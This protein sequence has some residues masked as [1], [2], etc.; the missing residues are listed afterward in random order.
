MAKILLK[1]LHSII[2][3]PFVAVPFFCTYHVFHTLNIALIRTT[4][5]QRITHTYTHVPPI[6]LSLCEM[7]VWIWDT[8]LVPPFFSLSPFSLSAASILSDRCPSRGRTKQPVEW[9]HHCPSFPYHAVLNSTSWVIVKLSQ[10]SEQPIA[11]CWALEQGCVTM[12]TCV[13]VSLCVRPK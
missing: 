1:S 11:R 12:D 4:N 8:S 9:G 6:L 5:T 3:F 2:D 13:C 7:F 10:S